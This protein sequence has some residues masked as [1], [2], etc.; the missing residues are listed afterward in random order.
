MK[1]NSAK[2]KLQKKSKKDI[3]KKKT[4]IGSQSKSQSRGDS[5]ITALILRDHEPIRS[6]ILVLKDSEV[7][8]TRKRIAY[9]EFEH[10]LSSHSKAEEKSLYIKMKKETDLKVIGL[11]GEIEHELADQLMKEIDQNRGDTDL[12]T[13]KVKVLAELVDHHIKEEET[14]VLKEIKLQFDSR[15]RALL[16]EEYQSLLNQIRSEQDGNHKY[17]ENEI[18]MSEYI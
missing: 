4:S 11:E 14:E 1:T 2:A 5:D 12:W 17:S 6:L 16:G 13:A 8:I 7:G 3:V 9:A 15:E 10:L 18:P